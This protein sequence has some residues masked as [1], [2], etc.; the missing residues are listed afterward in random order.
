[1]S[2]VQSVGPVNTVDNVAPTYSGTLTLTAEG[3][4]SIKVTWST[5]FTDGRG[6]TDAKV[7]YGTTAPT[8]TSAADLALW[9]SATT[10]YNQTVTTAAIAASGNAPVTG[11][12][13]GTTY[14]AYLSVQDAAGNAADFATSPASV[15][16][17]DDAPSS[18]LDYVPGA[19]VNEI[20][21]RNPFLYFQ[22]LPNS[23]SPTGVMTYT[24]SNGDEGF[25]VST[26]IG[27]TNSVTFRI[28]F[29]PL[30][31]SSYNVQI[32]IFGNTT[33]QRTGSVENECFVLSGQSGA[34][35]YY[36]QG[37]YTTTNYTDN[38]LRLLDVFITYK[39]TNQVFVK[40]A[41]ADSGAAVVNQTYTRSTDPFQGRTY[42]GFFI[43]RFFEFHDF[44][45]YTPAIL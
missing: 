10:T 23:V 30:L 13:A 1:M 39:G 36:S 27:P 6:I 22:K 34:P 8:S 37:G 33:S 12:T 16:T 21:V 44:D 5:G 9:K 38:K 43:K 42:F 35:V 32:D 3:E 26:L 18:Q 2:S 17:E 40:Y 20:Q 14:Y 28:R 25:L 11:L 41:D 15:A 29:K 45:I 7:Y 4:T 24:T 19:T 31:F